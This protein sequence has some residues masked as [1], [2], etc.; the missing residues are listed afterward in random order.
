MI[1]MMAVRENPVCGLDNLDVGRRTDL[2]DRVW[3]DQVSHPRDAPPL[4]RAAT[5]GGSFEHVNPHIS[6]QMA[7]ARANRTRDIKRACRSTVGRVDRSA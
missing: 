5:L 6:V 1:G 3:V 7:A 4:G 2:Q